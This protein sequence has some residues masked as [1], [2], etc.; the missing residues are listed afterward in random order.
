MPTQRS[1]IHQLPTSGK[2]AW[3]VGTRKSTIENLIIPSILLFFVGPAWGQVPVTTSGRVGIGTTSPEN[4]KL[5]IVGDSSG[6][7]GDHGWT[8]YNDP[9]QKLGLTAYWSNLGHFATLNAYDWTSNQLQPFRIDGA[10][11]VL[12][13]S[14][15]NVGIGTASPIASA[16]LHVAGQ[17]V[18]DGGCTPSS[19]ALKQGIA[20]FEAQDAYDAIMLSRPVHFEY[21]HKPGEPRVGFVSEEVP[22][23]VALRDRRGL[24]AMDFVAC[25]TKVVQEQQRR[26]EAQEHRIEELAARLGDD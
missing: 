5:N 22:E 21:R 26:L 16:K 12:N 11:L 4:G 2:L 14:A 10:P 6:Q 25:L 7:G 18:C 19:R 23:L 8:I 3:P 24:E 9:G 1:Q 13:A 17:V 15:G 20:D